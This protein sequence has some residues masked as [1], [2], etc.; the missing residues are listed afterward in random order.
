MN[1]NLILASL[2]EKRKHNQAQKVF[3]SCG[4][5]FYKGLSAAYN[6]SKVT[7]LATKV[8]TNSPLQDLEKQKQLLSHASKWADTNWRFG[9]RFSSPVIHLSSAFSSSLKVPLRKNPAAFP[10]L[11]FSGYCLSSNWLTASGF[12]NS[13][14]SSNPPPLPWLPD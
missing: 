14:P 8:N 3:S 13:P 6:Y 10:Q 11:H 7:L 2:F 1:S 9:F 12:S 5:K 4:E